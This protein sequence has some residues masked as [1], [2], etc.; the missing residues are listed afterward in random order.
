[1]M[2]IHVQLFVTVGR[3]TELL[4]AHQLPFLSPLLSIGSVL[5][6]E[7]PPEADFHPVFTFRSAHR[8]DCSCDRCSRLCHG[9][10]TDVPGLDPVAGRQ[11]T[12]MPHPTEETV[13]RGGPSMALDSGI[14][15]M[16]FPNC[17]WGSG[18]IQVIV[19]AGIKGEQLQTGAVVVTAN[20]P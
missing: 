1:M 17:G 20:A 3:V 8:G 18:G 15:Y 6:T 2:A 13:G 11:A 7:L 9:C 16:T 12:G 19:Q 10:S 5:M 14:F 4:P